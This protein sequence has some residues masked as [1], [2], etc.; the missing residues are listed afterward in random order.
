MRS[1][2]QVRLCLFGGRL[3]T[4]LSCGKEPSQPITIKHL[5]EVTDERDNARAEVVRLKDELHKRF[6]LEA[7]V[8]SLSLERDEARA[9]VEKLKAVITQ[10][11]LRQDET[12]KRL[13]NAEAQE[14]LARA[15]GLSDNAWAWNQGFKHAAYQGLT[16]VAG[17]ILFP[18]KEDSSDVMIIDPNSPLGKA[19]RD[20]P[21]C[22]VDGECV[23]G[24]EVELQVEGAHDYDLPPDAG[25]R[26]M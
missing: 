22:C 26:R 18:K 9:E 10:V 19:W 1:V 5:N 20:D 16:Y 24:T 23:C 21:P 2:W 15:G 11:M 12:F 7:G 17:A 14:K 6:E 3:M 13:K 4:C 25:Q 8:V